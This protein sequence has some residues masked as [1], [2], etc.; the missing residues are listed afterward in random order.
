MVGA[1]Y[2]MEES[3]KNGG[4]NKE[5]H[6]KKIA[7]GIRHLLPHLGKRTFLRRLLG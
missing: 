7:P 6:L 2:F 4:T 3:A 1:T 5:S